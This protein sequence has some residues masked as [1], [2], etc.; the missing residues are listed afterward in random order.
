[1]LQKMASVSLSMRIDPTMKETSD[2][3]RG[4]CPFSRSNSN[5][6]N[7]TNTFFVRDGLGTLMMADGSKYV[8]E[9]NDNVFQGVGIASY[10]NQNRYEGEFFKDKRYSTDT[11]FEK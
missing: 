8:G 10:V 3:G 5:L 1:M 7:H 6:L 2:V 4:R 9:W 11:H